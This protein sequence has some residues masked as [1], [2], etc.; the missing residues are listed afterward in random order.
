MNYKI[1]VH[2]E[3]SGAADKVDPRRIMG[4]Q[5]NRINFSAHG[6]KKSNEALYPPRVTMSILPKGA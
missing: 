3:W 4:Y 2:G 5:R 6:K 1:N